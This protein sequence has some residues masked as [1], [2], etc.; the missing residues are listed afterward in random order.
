MNLLKR[1]G[2]EL[3]RVALAAAVFA[4]ISGAGAQ[5]WKWSQSASSNA[6]ADPSINWAEGMAPSAVNDSARSM[7]AGLARY[8]DDISA[9]LVTGGSAG[10]FTLT[11]NQSMPNPPTTGQ[12]LAFRV[13]ATNSVG[14]TL[15]VDGGTAY[16]IYSASGV[17]VPDATLISGSPYRATF[18]GSAWVLEG[19]FGN[20]YAI[21]LGGLLHST[22]SSPPNSNFVKPVGQCLSTSTYATYWV[23]LGSPASGGCPGGQFAIIDVAGRSLVALDN[24]SGSAANRLTSSATGCGS[25]MNAMGATCANGTQAKNVTIANIDSFTPTVASASVN[26]AAGSVTIPLQG[27]LS[28]TG[29]SPT[30]S[31]SQG[32]NQTGGTTLNG[33]LSG[34]LTPAIT[35]NPLGSGT[36]HPTV[37]PNIAVYVYLRVL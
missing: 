37:D 26:L 12:M 23:A 35:I 2:A 15:A 1:Y 24:L 3:L 32:N 28:H 33:T 18:N 9:A 21:P 5:V 11:T 19:F 34:T 7:M 8:R 25:S 10:A 27:D 36:A 4:S 20:P 13:N 29:G 16:P 22:V 14:A 6:T 30:A 17:A 31:A